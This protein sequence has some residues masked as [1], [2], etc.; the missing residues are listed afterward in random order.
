MAGLGLD[1]SEPGKQA[2]EYLAE[3]PF[4]VAER[5]QL[6]SK[7]ARVEDVWARLAK[8]KS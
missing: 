6:S 3:D 8:F 4:V 5:D 2:A 7:L 1:G